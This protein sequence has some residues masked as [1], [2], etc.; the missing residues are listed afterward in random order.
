MTQISRQV[1]ILT[2]LKIDKEKHR[3][4]TGNYFQKRKEKTKTQNQCGL[5]GERK[6]FETL[7]KR[8]SC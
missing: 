2:T 7:K 4:Q 5:I 6:S 1:N 3:K 8:N